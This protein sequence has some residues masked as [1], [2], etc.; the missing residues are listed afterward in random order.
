MAGTQASALLGLA[1][2][3][4]PTRGLPRNEMPA[5]TSI[6][7]LFAWW[8]VAYHFLGSAPFLIGQNSD[9][10]NKGRMAVDC[11]FVLS[12]F[13]LCHV[14]PVIIGRKRSGSASPHPVADFLVSRL[15]RIYPLHLVMLAAFC[16]VVLTY[17]LLHGGGLGAGAHNAFAFDT[18]PALVRE[19]LL[20]HG[21][22]GTDMEAWNVP[23]WSISSEW[24]AYLLAPLIFLWLPRLRPAVLLAGLGVLGAITIL[25]AESG[26]ITHPRL[27]LPRV[28]LEFIIGAALRTLVTG[29]ISR[30]CD[31]R[32]IGLVIGWLAG[33]AA[34][35]SA[36]A[37]MF[38][39][40]MVWIM[41]LLSLRTHR[42][43]G[44][45]GRCERVTIY[46]GETSFAVYMCHALVL[47]LWTGSVQSRLAHAGI[48][49]H[50]LMCGLLLVA[51]IQGFA[52]GLH[53]AVE[54]PAQRAIR[55]GFRQWSSRQW[56]NE[57]VRPQ[58]N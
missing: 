22:L 17:R 37:G 43:T 10:L 23:S 16:A 8:V 44:W 51:V 1:R 40:V 53:H 11:F 49:S 5:L 41:L 47:M 52:S 4:D 54:L 6:R 58:P 56:A 19:A 20:L 21:W 46:L 39:A 2:S 35:F 30:L 32:G 9:F 7:A 48:G 27:E 15:A 24:G 13:V 29:D 38:L 33:V 26:E 12:G 18:L 25:L 34:A 45:L 55:Q 31:I 3:W 36:H 50:P 28:L 14:H 42:A 57:R